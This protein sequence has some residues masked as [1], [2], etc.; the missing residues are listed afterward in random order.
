MLSAELLARWNRTE[1]ELLGARADPLVRI[2]ETLEKQ[3]AELERLRRAAR[4]RDGRARRRAVE[5]H[6]ALLKRA[7]LQRWYL[8]VQRE[9]VGLRRHGIL[10]ELYPL[11][12][13]ID[14]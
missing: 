13:A 5:A 9:A 2:A 3:L 1:E 6:A 11:P 7:R 12:V 8:V 10:A 4:T 14:G